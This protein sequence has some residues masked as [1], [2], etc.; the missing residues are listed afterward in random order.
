MRLGL[1]AR[2]DNTGLGSQTYELARM[3]NPDKILLINSYTFNQNKQYPERYEKFNKVTFSTKRFLSREEIALF[4]KK[5]DVVFTCET[6]YSPMF[7]SVAERM[8]VKTILQ[9]N[10]EFLDY[11][12]SESLPFPTMLLSPSTW[13]LDD[14]KNK[15]NDKTKI[16]FLPPPTNSDNF[17]EV[18]SLNISKDH[19]RILHVAGKRADNDRNGTNT[20]IEMLK[21]S[22]EDYEL[23]IKTQSEIDNKYKDS[24]LTIEQNNLDN[25]QDLY[26]NFD[27]MVL[28]RRYAGLCLP[29]NEALI[30]G[31]PVFMTDISPNNFVLPKEWLIPSKKIGRFMTRTLL[32]IYEANPKHLGKTIDLYINKDKLSDKQK[33]FDIG[34]NNFS[35]DILKDKYN[36]MINSL[37]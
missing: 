3:L 13:N 15:F 7:I 4:L 26:K 27:A 30:S 24:R 25:R 17:K 19:R 21:Y 28:P 34:Y 22:K 31:L 32:D 18:R 8:G 9:Y 2:S 36:L 6:F 23:V 5:L 35:T 12:Q 33:A 20:V 1:I 11:L 14:V 16:E 10:Y 37:K 29:M